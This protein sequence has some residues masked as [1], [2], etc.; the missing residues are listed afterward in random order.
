VLVG[1]IVGIAFVPEP[2][3]VGLLLAAL[4]VMIGPMNVIF[5][6]YETR[7]VPDALSAR[8]S[9]AIDFGSSLLRAFGPLLAGLAAAAYGAS[10]A[11]LL[12]AVPVAALA[13]SAHVATG[14]H[15]LNQPIDEVVAAQPDAA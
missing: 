13:V 15:A 14:L 10:T 4:L 5:S 8:V 6:T 1:V 11:M 2:W 7:M 3:Q 9:N 12:V